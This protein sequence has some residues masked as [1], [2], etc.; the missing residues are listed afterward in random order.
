MKAHQQGRMKADRLTP[1]KLLSCFTGK[2]VG[3]SLIYACTCDVKFHFKY[4][5]GLHARI[6]NRGCL[7]FLRLHVT[8]HDRNCSQNALSRNGSR[9]SKHFLPVALVL[10]YV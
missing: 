8:S 1:T 3:L 2:D 9:Y 10:R 7:R 6:E 4:V 5:R